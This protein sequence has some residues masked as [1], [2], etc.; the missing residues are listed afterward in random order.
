M[1]EDSCGGN[2][3]FA[4]L[5]FLSRGFPRES[6]FL[7][8]RYPSMVGVVRACVLVLH[9]SP[10]FLGFCDLIML[11]CYHGAGPG[12]SLLTIKVSE[13]RYFQ[14]RYRRADNISLGGFM[15]FYTNALPC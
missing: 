12:A 1:L 7:G 6:L 4:N 2:I 3:D 5:F 15:I 10:F 13:G 14:L 11:S 9:C 8:V